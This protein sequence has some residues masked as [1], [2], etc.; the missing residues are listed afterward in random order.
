M[1]SID[2]RKLSSGVDIIES[3][4]EKKFFLDAIK[5]ERE[6]LLRLPRGLRSFKP[7]CAEPGSFYHSSFNNILLLFYLLMSRASLSGLLEN[8]LPDVVIAAACT[9]AMTLIVSA[10]RLE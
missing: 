2:S 6:H 3:S 1:L 8:G 7:H 9:S 10:M 4:R 5:W